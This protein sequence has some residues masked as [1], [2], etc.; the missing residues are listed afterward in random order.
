M[1]WN[2]EYLPSGKNDEE[3]RTVCTFPK[4]K[5]VTVMEH[6]RLPF[7]ELGT[8]KVG[9]ATAPPIFEVVVLPFFLEDTMWFGDPAD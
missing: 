5:E 8:V 9:S 6:G 4:F 3:S 7:L 1:A 2:D